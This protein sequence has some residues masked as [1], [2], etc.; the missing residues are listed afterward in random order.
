MIRRPPRSTQGV[1]SAASDV[2]KRQIFFSP[3]WCSCWREKAWKT[4]YRATARR[5]FYHARWN[6]FSYVCIP[7][8]SCARLLTRLLANLP[9][10]L[11]D[12]VPPTKP[13]HLSELITDLLAY[14]SA[15]LLPGGRLV[16]WLPTMNE[17]HAETAI[18]QHDHFDLVAHSV[19]NFGRWSRR[20]RILLFIPFL[21]LF[22]PRLV[23]S[24]FL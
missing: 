16:F 9:C 17:D 7:H 24:C 11:P 22:L 14:A 5:T 4:Q 2:Y 23:D 20:V 3:V 13:Y 18:P 19:Q 1:S 8:V 15:L 10:R 6:T 21:L 12:Y